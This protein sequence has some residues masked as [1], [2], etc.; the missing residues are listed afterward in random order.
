MKACMETP[1]TVLHRQA[2]QHLSQGVWRSGGQSWPVLPASAA[3][4]A[5]AGRGGGAWAC[6]QVG[7]HHRT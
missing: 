2:G 4:N 1:V 5:Y 3:E 6:W 7:R